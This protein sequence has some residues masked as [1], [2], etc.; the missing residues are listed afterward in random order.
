MAKERNDNVTVF[1]LAYF[2]SGLIGSTKQKFQSKSPKGAMHMSKYTLAVGIVMIAGCPGVAPEALDFP[3]PASQQTENVTP[4]S[5][6]Q[7]PGPTT[8]VETET[9][10]G[11][12]SNEVLVELNSTCIWS[13]L[14]TSDVDS[15]LRNVEENRAVGRNKTEALEAAARDCEVRVSALLRSACVNCESAVIDQLYQ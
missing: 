9:P 5:E 3:E 10:Q 4:E 14:T 7:T 11:L 13:G 8:P 12:V 2:N 15:I 1:P 6:A